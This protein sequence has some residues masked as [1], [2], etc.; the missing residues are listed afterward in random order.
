MA[1]LKAKQT[2]QD[3]YTRK[4][5]LTEN[6]KTTKYKPTA[7]AN[8]LYDQGWLKIPKLFGETVFYSKEKPLIIWSQEVSSYD[9]WVGE[10]CIDNYRHKC[11][12]NVK[13]TSNEFDKNLVDIVTKDIQTFLKSM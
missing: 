10:E 4:I 2:K 12:T 6:E 1:R 13:V 11:K 7:F 8:F 3:V 9:K 5:S